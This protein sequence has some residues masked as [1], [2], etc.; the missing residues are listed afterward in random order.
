V[1]DSEEDVQAFLEQKDVQPKSVLVVRYE[2]PKGGPGMRELS[3][4][5]ATLV[6]MGLHK[7]VAMITDGRFSGASRGPCV[8]HISPEAWEEGPLAYVEDGDMIEINIPEK[9]IDLLVPDE[10][11]AKRR[12]IPLKRP[13]HP[14]PGL[15]SAYRHLVAGAEIGATWLTADTMA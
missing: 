11:L 7:S 9:R 1:F 4:P 8:G 3:I 14:A 12:K 6:G 13:E 15:L 10:V 5:A 2:G